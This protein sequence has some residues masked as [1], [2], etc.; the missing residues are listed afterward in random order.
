[1]SSRLA[2]RSLV[3]AVTALGLAAVLAVA[4]AIDSLLL[5]SSVAASL[6]LIGTEP[7][8][9]ATSPRVVV[10]AYAIA[11]GAGVACSLLFDVGPAVIELGNVLA[12]VIAVGVAGALMIATRSVHAPAAGA[13][14]SMGAT[15]LRLADAS[16]MISAV[17]LL[18]VSAYTLRRIT[19]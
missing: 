17:T 18:A 5:L 9:H 14:V 7:R 6:F 15:P 1:M 11:F 10:S 12:A 16:V 13:A 8:A 19:Q 3:P 2:Q 4:M